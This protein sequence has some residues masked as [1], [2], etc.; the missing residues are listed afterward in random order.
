MFVEK[1]VALFGA[2]PVQFEPLL[3]VMSFVAFLWLCD[4]IFYTLR[5]LFVEKVV[6]L[7]GAVPVQFEP[8]LYVMS[9]VAFLWLCDA[10]FYTLRTLIGG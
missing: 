1:V 7:F 3:Y 8:L 4:A 2:V 10:I 6:A 5:F 9:F